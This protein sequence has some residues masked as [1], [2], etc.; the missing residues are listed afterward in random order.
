[1]FQYAPF[2]ASEDLTIISTNF[3]VQGNAHSEYLGPL[4]EQGAIG[5]LL[6][7]ALV[8]IT[9][10]ITLRAYPRMPKG[11]DK[12]LL[13]AVYLG[14]VTYYLHGALNNFLDTDKAS[15]PFWAFTALIVLLDLKY[16]AQPK[17]QAST[18]IS[19]R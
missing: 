1:M 12:A 14:S 16:P 11:R 6:M 3:G 8:V 7:V 4:S 5:M 2:Q 17:L 15:V 9:T 18:A 13:M 10:M 19:S